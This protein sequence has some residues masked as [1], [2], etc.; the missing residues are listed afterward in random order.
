MN[1]E[2]ESKDG[3][4]SSFSYGSRRNYFNG[5]AQKYRWLIDEP[6][7]LVSISEYDTHLEMQMVSL[8]FSV[9]SFGRFRTQL[10][11]KVKWHKKV[12]I[13]T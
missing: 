6:V 5:T 2:G 11:L 10:L 13:L 3:R 7:Q 8:P 1:I 4:N 9:F 12:I